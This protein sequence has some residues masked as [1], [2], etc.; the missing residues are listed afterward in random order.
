MRKPKDISKLLLT[1]FTA[2]LAL[3]LL[4]ELY[5][6]YIAYQQGILPFTTYDFRHVSDALVF[7]FPI[8][9]IL[10]YLLPKSKLISIF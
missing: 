1:S 7:F 3:V 9:P 2:S 4:V 6:Y 5:R 10:W 8:L